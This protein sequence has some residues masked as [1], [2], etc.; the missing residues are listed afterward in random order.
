MAGSCFTEAFAPTAARRRAMLLAGV[1]AL[2][3]YLGSRGADNSDERT[4]AGPL[5]AR[6]RRLFSSFKVPQHSRASDDA[7]LYI[8]A[9][10]VR[11]GIRPP[12]AL[13]AFVLVPVATAPGGGG[14]PADARTFRR[15]AFGRMDVF[16]PLVEGALFELFPHEAAITVRQTLV[17]GAAVLVGV[18]AVAVD[19]G[20]EGREPLDVDVRV[21]RVVNW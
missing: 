9:E 11:S 3:N 16:A 2:G 13:Q 20:Q 15:L 7:P 8:E 6:C 14:A 5:T 19:A 1:L 18:E 17:P 4:V 12:Y 10:L 21:R